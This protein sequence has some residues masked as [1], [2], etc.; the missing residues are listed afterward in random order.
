MSNQR[1]INNYGDLVISSDWNDTRKYLLS[2][3]VYS[4]MDLGVDS[5]NDLSVAAGVALQPDGILWEE[6]AAQSVSFTPPGGATNYTVVATHED[7]LIKGGRPV[8]YEIQT[9]LS[10]TVTNGIPLG[11]IYHPGGGVPLSTDHL[12]SAP[13]QGVTY[14]QLLLDTQPVELY[15]PLPR[16]FSDLTGAGANIVLTGQTATDLLFDTTY[17]VNHQ[18]VAKPAGPVGPP[19][20]LTQHVQFIMGDHRP[21]G[22]DLYVNIA[23][24]G[25]QL[26][27]ELRDTD[28]NIVTITGSPFSST[29]NWEWLSVE[30]DRTDGVFA[31]DKPYELRLTHSVDVGQEIKLAA[32]RARFWPFPT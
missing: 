7:V 16:T 20:T 17:F 15:A 28:L 9:G 21:A 25:Q 27:L 12:V 22:F 31:K 19:E 4:G 32:V 2:P 24:S 6:D 30:V 23:A 5:S 29:T 11:W 3:G 18:R 14:S 8:L 26:Q 13:K 1:R 10:A